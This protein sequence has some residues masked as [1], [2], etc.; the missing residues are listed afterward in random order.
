M[1]KLSGEKEAVRLARICSS[2]SG[3]M[4]ASTTRSSTPGGA[5]GVMLSEIDCVVAMDVRVA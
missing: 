3:V 4:S 1:S 5:E 2:Y